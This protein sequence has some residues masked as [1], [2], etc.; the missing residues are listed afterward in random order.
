MRAGTGIRWAL[1]QLP[2]GGVESNILLVQIFTRTP[3]RRHDAQIVD[4]PPRHCQ[5]HKP[6]AAGRTKLSKR[7]RFGRSGARCR[8]LIFPFSRWPL[9]REWATNHDFPGNTPCNS[10]RSINLTEPKSPYGE[11]PDSRAKLRLYWAFHHYSKN[12]LFLAR[13][14]S[15]VPP[16]VGKGSGN[17]AMDAAHPLAVAWTSGPYQSGV[18]ICGLSASTYGSA[19]CSAGN[20][21]AP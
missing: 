2:A 4:N 21:G 1:D 14:F 7:C 18:F 8:P 10:A 13:F 17:A 3:V 6:A 12:R 19:R 9:A 15:P 16:S 20:R 11:R 5:H